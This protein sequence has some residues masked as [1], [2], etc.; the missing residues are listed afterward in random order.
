MVKR[1][2]LA[3]ALALEP[4]VLILDEPT[5]GLDPI[6]ASGFDDLIV[7]LR[8][9]LGLSVIMVTHDLQ[10]LVTACDRIAALL[11]GKAIC[12]TLDEL[13]EH[14]HTW[15]LQYFRGDRMARLLGA[16]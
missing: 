3:R 2:A 4:E 8:D 6:S 14:P 12:G 7:H 10:S 11:D 16:A 5:A 9:T 15:A 1:A 13:R